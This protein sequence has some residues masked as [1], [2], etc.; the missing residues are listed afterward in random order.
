MIPVS[1]EQLQK[2]RER[3]PNIRATRTV[4]KYFIEENPKVMAYIKNGEKARRREHA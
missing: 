2:I 3:F 4:H 1:K